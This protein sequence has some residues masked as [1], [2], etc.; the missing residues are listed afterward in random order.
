MIKNKVNLILVPTLRVTNAVIFF[1]L[2]SSRLVT[3]WHGKL[4]L[5]ESKQPSGSLPYQSVTQLELR[6]EEKTDGHALLCPS[7][8]Y[9]KQPFDTKRRLGKAQRAQRFNSKSISLTPSD[10]EL[11]GHN[12]LNLSACI[13]VPR[14]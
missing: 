5:T 1:S 13:A 4:Q 6:N 7:Y 9:T 8:N 12:S 11:W 14:L 10:M 3:H 2:P